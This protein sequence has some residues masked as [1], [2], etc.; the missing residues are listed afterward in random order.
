MAAAS[1]TSPGISRLPQPSNEDLAGN[2][3][4]SV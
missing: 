4:I 1:T 3:I 2:G